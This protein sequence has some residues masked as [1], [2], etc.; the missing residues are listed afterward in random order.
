MSNTMKME[1]YI[2][3][4][5]LIIHSSYHPNIRLDFASILLVLVA[6]HYYIGLIK[7]EKPFFMK[8]RTELLPFILMLDLESDIIQK[9]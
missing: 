8:K 5:G 6:I 4:Y 3:I 7:F 2:F 9:F 1:N